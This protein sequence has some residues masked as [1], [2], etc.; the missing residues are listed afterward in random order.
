[1]LMVYYI[2]FTYSVLL[3]II[4]TIVVI[5]IHL[6]FYIHQDYKGSEECPFSITYCA[7]EKGIWQ[8]RYHEFS[9]RF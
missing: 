3:Y 5:F 7:E 6:S 1:M 8:V 4:L 2:L 9:Y